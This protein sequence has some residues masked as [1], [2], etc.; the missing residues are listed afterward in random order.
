MREMSVKCFRLQGIFMPKS[1]LT[2]Q[3]LISAG[4]DS[5]LQFPT[6][7]Y[8]FLINNMHTVVELTRLM[9]L[10]CDISQNK[11]NRQQQ[12]VKYARA[13]K[14]EMDS[15]AT[16]STLY[17]NFSKFK[18]Y[19]TW[20]DEKSISPFCESTWRHYRSYLWELVLAG[21][22]NIPM[23]Q[24]PKGQFLGI[25]ER[26]AN[27]VVSTV[28]QA[29]VWC[30]ENVN[31][32]GRQLRPFKNGK[33][34]SYEAYSDKELPIILNR[35]SSYFFQLAIPLLSDDLPSKINVEI[36]A[37][38]F[39]VSV[40]SIGTKGKA[41]QATL[42]YDT[43]FN[44]AMSCA[45]YLLS[46][47]TAFNSS[48]L[49]ELRHPIE[50][51]QD[52]T[53][54]YYKLTAYKKRANK[55]VI[56]FVGGEIHKK[57]IQFMETLIALSLKY[58][59]APNG[60][61]VYWLDS[62][63][64]P[65]GLSSTLLRN[66]QIS[67]QLLLL[68]DKVS[69]CLPYLLELHRSFIATG[70]N[71][72][73]EFTDHKVI[74]RKLTKQKKKVTRFFSR[75]IVILSMQLLYAIIHIHPK[76]KQKVVKLKGALLPLTIIR[77]GQDIKATLHC[78][79][80]TNG[81]FYID[82]KHQQFLEDI[83]NFASARQ[84]KSS[85]K[86]RYLLPL[87]PARQT[88]QWEG[89]IPN[90]NYLSDYGIANGEFFISLQS[91]RF[92]ETAAK[93]ARRKA[94]RTELQVSQIL[95][96]QY[97]TV[98][99]HYTEGNHYDNQLILAQGLSVI[100]AVSQGHTIKQAKKVVALESDMAVIKFEELIPNNASLNGIGVACSGN[101]S[102]RKDDPNN[103][104]CFDYESCIKCKYA[105]LVDDV[106]PLYRLLSFLECMEESWLYYPERFTQNIG[107]SIELYR[108]VIAENIPKAT[109]ES[110]QIKLDSA[111]RHMLWD[112][113]ELASMGY[114]GT[115]SQC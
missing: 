58:N 16:H 11:A 111:G 102:I 45:Y 78:V 21:R 61:F 113:L 106:E 41:K 9:H 26:T 55:E 114:K 31:Q 32:W 90:T 96:N 5:T 24:R 59:K 109:F 110:A 94:N 8:S 34:E 92:R 93:L 91:S 80:G 68:S 6:L 17:N 33:P 71:G 40:N 29:L 79:D 70:I 73:V 20:C 51:Q 75:R 97:R 47:F 69:T 101:I 105:K 103:S 54:E 83:K 57:S 3:K 7:H 39:D 76:N 30:E 84:N 53:T 98:I 36:L 2:G 37:H 95:N 60:L 27:Y 38:S 22:S 44:Q 13:F 56:S 89:I 46:Y 1:K 49:V 115:T 19:L 12:I 100:E 104:P 67:S 86:P 87:G 108:K 50:W 66:S 18:G 52:K 64:N 35:L 82:S 107:K 15:G 63:F 72:Y 4:D 23:W 74:D 99:K 85:T 10:K 81:E 62:N 42:N 77:N 112:N 43:A 25:K 48:Q 88:L 65:K 28:E 14:K